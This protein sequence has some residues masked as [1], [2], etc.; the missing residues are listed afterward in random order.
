MAKGTL[1]H[2]LYSRLVLDKSKLTAMAEQV[3]AVAQLPDPVGKTL[4][5]TI[6]DDKLV[7]TK[8]SCPIGVLAV[9]FESRPD[10]MTVSDRRAVVKP[11]S[12]PSAHGPFRHSEIHPSPALRRG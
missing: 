4:A 2:S 1:S 12:D 9:I 7:L 5:T 11:W 10:A 8:V 3:R 6:L